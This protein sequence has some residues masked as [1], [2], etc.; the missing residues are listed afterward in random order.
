VEK[1]SFF[2]GGFLPC[3]GLLVVA[4]GRFK[5]GVDIPVDSITEPYV[6]ESVSSNV[7]NNTLWY[8]AGS[9]PAAF[10]ACGALAFGKGKFKL[11]ETQVKK[12][13]SKK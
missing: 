13:P 2:K 4:Y 7:Y 1:P 6:I 3:I 9:L 11:G 12:L 5:Y 10:L 8:R